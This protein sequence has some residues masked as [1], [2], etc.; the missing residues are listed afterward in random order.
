MN[1]KTKPRELAKQ[2]TREAVIRA[3]MAAFT[4]EGVDLPSLDAI[5]AR[6]GF[7]RGA[8]YRALEAVQRGESGA[9]DP[10]KLVTQIAARASQRRGQNQPNRLLID[11]ALQRLSEVVRAEQAQ[12]SV[13]RE[14]EPAQ[15]GLLLASSAVGFIG[16]LGG[17]YQPDFSEVRTLI[18]RWLF[19]PVR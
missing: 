15:L 16:L 7:T 11:G 5:C 4:E 14:L 12:G 19:T 10:H 18:D 6:A 2:E 9:A 1:G 13:R 3:G 8:F 17:G